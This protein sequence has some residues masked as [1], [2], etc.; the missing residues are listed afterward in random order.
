MILAGLYFLTAKNPYEDMYPSY[1]RASSEATGM[2]VG[3]FI[4]MVLGSLLYFFP[5][6]YLYRFSAQAK[7][8][9][10]AEDQESL[11]SSMQNLKSMFKFMGILTIILISLY[12]LGLLASLGSGA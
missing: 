8:A 6:L 12:I 7:I 11:T 5:C 3:M 1:Y 4:G 2:K 10:E 9:V